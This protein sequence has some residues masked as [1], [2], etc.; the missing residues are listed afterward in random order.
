MNIKQL[1][2]MQNYPLEMKVK[3]TEQ[4]LREFVYKCGGVNNCYVA[5]SGG[6]DSTVLVHIARNIFPSIEI[7][8][9][10]TGL[11]F[12]EVVDHVKKFENVTIVRPKTSFK[13]VIE[14]EGYPIISKQV[15]NTIYYAR[16]NIKE[17]KNTLRVRQIR[18]EEK[19]SKFNK[20][21]W[22]FLLNAPFK[23]S[24]KCCD[25]LKKEPLKTFEKE[26]GK[27][28]IV[29]T[30]A[31]ESRQRKM[32]YIQTGCNT[33]TEGKEM[34]R[35]LGFWTEQDILQ[36]CLDYVVEIPSIYGDIKMR[37]IDDKKE[38]EG[39][40]IEYYTTG[41]KRTGCIF[42]GFGLHLEK[43][44]NRFQRL[45]KSHPQLHNYCMDKLG[46]KDVC[47]FINVEYRAK[48]SKYNE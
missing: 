10:N 34:C 3:L 4:R 9:S 42:C 37:L 28:P 11:E 26:T 16:K 15:A 5:F 46:F 33:F 25:Y 18:G 35:P 24:H 2:L 23:V 12:P 48:E 27:K 7:V 30:M 8:F 39:Y 13:Q 14:K 6:K 40:R 43:G 32:S 38:K 44:E 19:G 36:Y 47:E 29:G 21:K 20:G 22:E 17:G 31:T 41:E 1:E 45:E